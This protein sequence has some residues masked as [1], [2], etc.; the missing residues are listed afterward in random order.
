[1]TASRTTCGKTLD[2]GDIGRVAS[3][4]AAT[5]CAAGAERFGRLPRGRWFH[6]IW[7]HDGAGT[8]RLTL[9]G[10]DVAAAISRLSDPPRGAGLQLTLGGD[11]QG[12]RPWPGA[13]AEVAIAAGAER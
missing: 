9:D 10:R 13:I 4:L 11:R 7:R 1:M 3:R 12:G 5:V 2:R 8:L 6:V